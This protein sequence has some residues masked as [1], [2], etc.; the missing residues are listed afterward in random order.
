MNCKG[1]PLDLDSYLSHCISVT[2]VA[3]K[4]HYGKYKNSSIMQT[5]FAIHGVANS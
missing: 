5:L 1:L 3:T 2:S 4:I